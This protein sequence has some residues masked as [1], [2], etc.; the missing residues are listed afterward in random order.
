MLKNVFIEE[1]WIYL[2]KLDRKI[3]ATQFNIIKLFKSE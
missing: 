3:T 1:V 2:S